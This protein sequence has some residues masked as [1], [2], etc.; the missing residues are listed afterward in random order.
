[1]CVLVG[2]KLIVRLSRNWSQINSNSSR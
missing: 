1:M 2:A